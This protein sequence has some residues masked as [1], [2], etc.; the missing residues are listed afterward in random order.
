MAYSIDFR[1]KVIEFIGRGHSQRS[2]AKVFGIHQETVNQWHQ[3]YRKTGSLEKKPCLRKFKKIDPEKLKS[4]IAG[5]CDAYLKEIGEV[6]DCSGAA[7]LK[8]FKRLGITRKKRR[9][10]SRNRTP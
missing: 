4:Y 2:A 8:A 1:K 10:V 9:N 3:Q 6:F 5:H 7:I